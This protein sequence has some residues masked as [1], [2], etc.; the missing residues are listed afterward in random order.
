MLIY[1]QGIF[2]IFCPVRICF[3]ATRSTSR[4]RHFIANPLFLTVGTQ[5]FRCA[6]TPS[7][8]SSLP[9]TGPCLCVTFSCLDRRAVW[10]VVSRGQRVY[11]RPKPRQ[12]VSPTTLDRQYVSLFVILG[13]TGC[14]PPSPSPPPAPGQ[15]ANVDG[16]RWQ[17]PEHSL[18]RI[19]PGVG[20]YRTRCAFFVVLLY[21]P[22]REICMP[23]V[24]RDTLDALG[25]PYALQ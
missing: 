16:N 24:Q 10:C 7:L 23:E 13:V 12:P 6:L 8:A 5:K 9:A 20:C 19:A 22:S 15:A 21:K 11:R 25:F 17:W 3:F 14:P 18:G 1:L 4:P 2:L